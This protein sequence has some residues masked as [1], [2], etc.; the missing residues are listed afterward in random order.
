[1]GRNGAWLKHI[2]LSN[3]ISLE[4]DGNGELVT[5]DSDPQVSMDEFVEKRRRRRSILSGVES[6]INQ[7][8]RQTRE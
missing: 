8:N 6:V 7:I 2:S 5:S 1:M 3:R 4:K